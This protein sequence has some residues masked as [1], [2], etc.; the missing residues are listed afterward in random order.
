MYPDALSQFMYS[1]HDNGWGPDED[2][3]EVT[4]FRREM[5]KKKPGYIRRS[6]A[7]IRFGLGGDT[8]QAYADPGGPEEGETETSPN[9]A[10]STGG[11]FP[12][13]PASA[14]DSGADPAGE[15]DFE[16]DFQAVDASAA[17]GPGAHVNEAVGGV[18]QASAR[19]GRSG[20]RDK[21]QEQRNRRGVCGFG[22]D[23]RPD[24]GLCGEDG[25][26]AD[27]IRSTRRHSPTLRRAHTE[28][29]A[30]GVQVRVAR[31]GG[32][33]RSVTRGN[34]APRWGDTL[35]VIVHDKGKQYVARCRRTGEKIAYSNS[36]EE[37]LAHESGH[38]LDRLHGTRDAH[39]GNDWTSGEEVRGLQAGNEYRKLARIP[40][41]RKYYA[42]PGAWSFVPYTRYT[43]GKVCK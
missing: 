20:R 4:R 3:D 27:L 16:A 23:G 5:K 39:E 21:G 18:R 8:E 15:A 40:V 10:F 6:A 29:K 38:V 26:A 31:R 1:I 22:P 30:K 28:A 13:L 25:R 9:G 24:R 35:W 19:P 36:P 32:T 43:V 42:E 37:A 11:A 17:G 34:D 14:R 33:G 41:E 12:A 2:E 7:A